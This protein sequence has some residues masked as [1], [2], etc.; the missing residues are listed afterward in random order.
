[1]S[2]DIN[3]QLDLINKELIED[4][5]QFLNNPL[6]PY[7]YQ[8]NILPFSPENELGWVRTS[9]KD[10]ANP[11]NLE[12]AIQEG[13]VPISDETTQFHEIAGKLGLTEDSFKEL[14][15]NP[16]ISFKDGFIRTKDSI[17]C[18]RKKREQK[19]HEYRLLFGQT[20]AAGLIHAELSY[21]E[22]TDCIELLTAPY[23]G[24]F[25]VDLKNMTT[26]VLYSAKELSEQMPEVDRILEPFM[27]K[28]P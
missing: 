10:E 11:Q 7:P 20:T 4:E 15:K 21:N 17:L 3:I 16:H 12:R 24:E 9:L 25:R 14:A 5:E 27:E 6:N 2:D 19:V 8:L 26:S 13:W 18:I 23:N 22:E 1:M 28:L